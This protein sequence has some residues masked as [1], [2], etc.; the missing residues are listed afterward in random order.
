MLHFKHLFLIL[1]LAATALATHVRMTVQYTKA[2]ETQTK[3]NIRKATCTTSTA[4]AVA[5]GTWLNNYDAWMHN[6][7]LRLM[8]SDPLDNPTRAEIDD[9]FKDMEKILRDH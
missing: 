1:F 5:G 4:E 8:N 7:E 3:S 2:G 6:G 9:A